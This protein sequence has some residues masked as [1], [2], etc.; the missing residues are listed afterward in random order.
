METVIRKRE[1]MRITFV[2]SVGNLI[3][4][5][6]KFVAGIWGHSSAMLADAVH[7]LSDFVTDVVV[8]VFVNISS[9]PKDAGHDYGHGKYETLATSIIGLALLV[10][11]VSLF[12]DS[13]HKVFDYW[14]L[15]EPLESPGWIA[16]MAALVSILIKE[17]LFQITYRVGKRQNSQAVIANAWHHRS[18]AL[19]SIGTTLGIGGAILLGPDWHVLDPLA[20]MVVS[21]FIVKVSLELMIPA[22]ND[23]L[24][25]SLPKEVENEILSIISENPKVKE[26][27]NLRT[28]RIGNDFAIEVHIRVDG[29]MSVREAHALT[30]EIERKLY[31]KYGN[32]TH[33]VI[34]VEPFRPK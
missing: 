2:G 12:W 26:P 30:K 17:L 25:Q 5:L 32:T 10:V 4:L 34:H 22:I 31:Q 19:S 21:V 29:D 28:R 24:E 13:L 11:G 6:F 15:G 1:L 23:L 3:L 16:L 33:V 18:D 14:V 20:A 9:K 8:I 27:H 7:S